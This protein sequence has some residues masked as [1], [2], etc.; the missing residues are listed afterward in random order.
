MSDLLTI[1]EFYEAAVQSAI[2]ND[3]RGK[4]KVMKSL[5]YAKKEYE[6]ITDEKDKKY[7]D[8]ETL[9]NP[10]A[11]SRL[12]CGDEN[13]NVSKIICGVDLEV[14]ELLLTDRLNEKGA[15]IDFAIAHHPEGFAM[16]NFYDVMYM[17]SDIIADWGV[18]INKSEGATKKRMGEIEK[19]VGSSNHMRS[20]DAAKLLDIPYACMHTLA[21]NHVATFLTKL[22]ESENPHKVS[23]VLEMIENTQEFDMASKYNNPPKMFA[24]SKKNRAGKVIV[25][26]TGGTTADVQ[27]ISQLAAAG[28]GTMVVMHLPE[29]HRKECEKQYINVVCAGHMGSDSLGLNL[30][31]DDI[32]D[33]TKKDFEIVACS[34]YLLHT[35]RI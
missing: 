20:V 7:F 13:K 30:L 26:M 10:Y 4:E 5:E 17:Q 21:D 19:R 33:I 32:K 35:R 3:P 12:L 34:G 31:F 16:A 2:N 22:I 1:K 8:I 25:D 27:V 18:P 6:K 23:E 29:E 24:G 14:G 15:N 11:D 9:K 28:V